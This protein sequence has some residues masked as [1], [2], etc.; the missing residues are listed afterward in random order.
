MACHF[1]LIQFPS[2]DVHEKIFFHDIIIDSQ[3]NL[4]RERYSCVLTSP[5]KRIEGYG[6]LE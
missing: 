2:I 6:M 1:D 3:S 4:A 5:S